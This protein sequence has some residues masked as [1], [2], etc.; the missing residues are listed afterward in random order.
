M[1]TGVLIRPMTLDDV[2]HVEQVTADAFYELDVA[3]RPADWPAPERRPAARTEPWRVRLRHLV[4]TDADGCWVAEADGEIVGAA[5]ALRREGLWGLSTYAVQ[6]GL[7]ARGI[8][9]KLLDAALSYGSPESPGI[10]CSSHDPRAVRRYRLAGFDLHPALLLWGTVRR[11]A[12]PSLPGVREGGADDI[13]LLDEI[14]R[15]SRGHGHG[16]DH[17]VMVTQLALRIYERGTSRAYAYLHPSGGPHL[18]S[19][20]DVQ[21]ARSVLWAALEHSAPDTRVDFHNVTAEQSWALDV[22][23]EAGMEVHNR[24]FVA[25]RSMPVPTPYIPS[26]HFL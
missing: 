26:G 14:D 15:I 18:L 3:T 25:L 21:S 4:N 23:L 10:I 11:S 12:I 16:V 24:A 5:A 17:E 1:V 20:T 19:A 2:P 22:G 7:Q 9:R 13:G 6:P 8:G